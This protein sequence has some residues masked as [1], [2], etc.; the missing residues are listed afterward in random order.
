MNGR[1]TPP[2]KPMETQR[3]MAIALFSVGNYSSVAT[4]RMLYKI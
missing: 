1:L 3:L 4:V 2:N